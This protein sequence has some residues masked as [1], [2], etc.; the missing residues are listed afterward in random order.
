[1]INAAPAYPLALYG[2]SGYAALCSVAFLG[3]L[4]IAGLLAC[5]MSR[6]GG[7]GHGVYPPASRRRHCWKC[8][9]DLTGNENGV[10]PECGRAT[11]V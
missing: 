5:L 9:Y 8:S 7:A 3:L 2:G 1:M 6:R 4:F 10:C 11:E